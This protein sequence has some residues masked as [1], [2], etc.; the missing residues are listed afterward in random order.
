MGQLRDP[1]RR[2]IEWKLQRERRRL[3]EAQVLRRT[4]SSGRAAVLLDRYMLHRPMGQQRA[5]EGDQL[6]VR[7]V[8]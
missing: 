5:I 2:R 8:S 6:D 3:P 7:V 1:H 4:S